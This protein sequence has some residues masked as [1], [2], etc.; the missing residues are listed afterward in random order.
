[1]VSSFLSLS[2]S[3][4]EYTF[5]AFDSRRLRAYKKREMRRGNSFLFSSHAAAVP[6]HVSSLLFARGKSC[7]LVICKARNAKFESFLFLETKKVFL[8]P[9]NVC[10]STC[11]PSLILDSFFKKVQNVSSFCASLKCAQP[12]FN[13]IE[14]GKSE[15]REFH[16]IQV[17]GNALF[18][19]STTV[20]SPST[21]YSPP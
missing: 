5:L 13:T 19:Y 2:L 18:H 20:A 12:P 7:L 3:R 16:P 1:M 8:M 11:F 17:H 4:G 21:Y 10:E 14:A 6:F 15:T 9:E